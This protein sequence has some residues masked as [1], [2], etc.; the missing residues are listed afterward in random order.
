M[1]KI[2][3]SNLISFAL[4]KNLEM[5]SVRVITMDPFANTISEIVVCQLKV[6]LTTLV[7]LNVS[8]MPSIKSL[9]TGGFLA[10]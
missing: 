3:A 9:H 10:K 2:I 4:K 6:K 1:R 8:W 7:I 5:E